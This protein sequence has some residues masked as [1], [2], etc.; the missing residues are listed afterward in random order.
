LPIRKRRVPEWFDKQKAD[1]AA[2]SVVEDSVTPEFEEQKRE[3]L[4]KLGVTE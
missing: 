1:R 2:G 4:E 3:L